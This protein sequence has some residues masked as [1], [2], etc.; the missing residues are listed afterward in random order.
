MRPQIEVKE[1]RAGTPEA[2]W[3]ERILQWAESGLAQVEFCREHGLSLDEFRRYRTRLSRP[4][5]AASRPTRKPCTPVRPT[6]VEVT[7]S[8]PAKHETPALAVQLGNGR[9]ITVR[10]GFDR[11]TLAALVAVLEG[12]P[13]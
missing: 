9:S 10:P 1:V 3:R 7:V 8:E 5:K 13:C 2:L 6:F 12:L 11:D 4:A